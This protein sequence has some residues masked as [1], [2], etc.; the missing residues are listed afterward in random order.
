MNMTNQP[1]IIPLLVQVALTF[2]VWTWLLLARIE[3]MRRNRVSIQSLATREGQERLSD[4]MKVSDNFENQ[5]EIP[6][7]FYALLV[8]LMFTYHSDATY[9]ICA[10]LFVLTRA[11]HAIIHCTVNNVA[12]RFTAHFLGSAI[13][14]AMWVRFAIQVL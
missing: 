6:V 9:L 4:V 2:V 11:I 3:S 5:F 7:L 10:W 8:T 12:L 14:G 1:L 13:L